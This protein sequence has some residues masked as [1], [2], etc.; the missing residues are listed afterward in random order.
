MPQEAAKKEIGLPLAIDKKKMAKEQE[1]L[2]AAREVI[3]GI[4]DIAGTAGEV[5]LRS[6]A[7]G[8]GVDFKIA[9][10][11]IVSEMRPKGDTG[12]YIDG[13]PI[14]D[15]STMNLVRKYLKAEYESENKKKKQ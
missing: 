13:K 2:A 5:A 9:N 7:Q 12:L 3:T 8:A 4:T 6:F 11:E 15:A 10:N 14:A 1:K